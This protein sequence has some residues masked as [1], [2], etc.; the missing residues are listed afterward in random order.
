MS[1]NKLKFKIPGPYK[2]A[3]CFIMDIQT[4]YNKIMSH[5]WPTLSEFAKDHGLTLKCVQKILALGHRIEHKNNL[6]K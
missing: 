1:T 3:P 6:T 5:Y 2:Q 4:Y